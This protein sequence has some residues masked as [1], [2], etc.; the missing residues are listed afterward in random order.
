MAFGGGTFGQWVGHKN[1]TLLSGIS[2]LRE[3]TTESSLA[4]ST[5]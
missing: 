3:E 1:G 5:V 2:A 4:P